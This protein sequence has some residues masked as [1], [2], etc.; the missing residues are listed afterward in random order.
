MLLSTSP[1]PSRMRLLT[2]VYHSMIRGNRGRG[3]VKAK[4][5]NSSERKTTL[6]TFVDMA[7]VVEVVTVDQRSGFEELWAKVERSLG[8][9]YDT[10]GHTAQPSDEEV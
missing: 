4:R 9:F 7:E 2:M 10:A 6:S 8:R 3:I 5:S 1:T